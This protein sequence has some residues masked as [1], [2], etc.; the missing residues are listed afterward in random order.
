MVKIYRLLVLILF[1]FFEK[2]IGKIFNASP[3]DSNLFAGS[4]MNNEYLIDDFAGILALK[5]EM[6]LLLS[7]NIQTNNDE[8][9][10]LFWKYVGNCLINEDLYKKKLNNEHNILEIYANIY[11]LGCIPEV[12]HKVYRKDLHKQCKEI[13]KEYNK[14]CEEGMWSKL[15]ICYESKLDPYILDDVT[16][17]RI[18]VNLN[19]SCCLLDIS[20]SSL[21][22][23]HIL[24][25]VENVERQV[26]TVLKFGFVL[27]ATRFYGI[28]TIMLMK[29]NIKL[30]LN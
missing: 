10:V 22:I 11:E 17:D 14:D 7:K 13:D 8:T 21:K 30:M 29:L 16:D 27:G 28:M 2:I 1:V 9:T 26:N 12:Y 24:D 4:R 20:F 18:K 25:M 5:L 15:T 19:E 3:A 23:F 6:M